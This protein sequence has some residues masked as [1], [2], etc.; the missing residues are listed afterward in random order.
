MGFKQEV[1]FGKEKIKSE[2]KAGRAEGEA[3]RAKIAQFFKNIYHK[4]IK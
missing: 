1:Q 4:L 3:D 2:F